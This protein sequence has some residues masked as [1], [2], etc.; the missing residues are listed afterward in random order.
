M[1]FD[2][3]AQYRFE[4]TYNDDQVYKYIIHRYYNVRLVAV[5][6]NYIFNNV[7]LLIG[8]LDPQS[9]Y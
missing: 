8:I 5:Y 4:S 1:V 3:N 2:Y 6:N 7:L 9:C